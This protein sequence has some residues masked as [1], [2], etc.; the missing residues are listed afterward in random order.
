MNKFISTNYPILIGFIISKLIHVITYLICVKLWD[1]IYVPASCEFGY[2][3][4]SGFLVCIGWIIPMVVFIEKCM[5][6]KRIT[7]VHMFSRALMICSIMG[8]HICLFLSYL[9]YTGRDHFDY[10]DANHL[11]GHVILVFIYGFMAFLFYM[12]ECYYFAIYIIEWYKHRE[13]DYDK[14]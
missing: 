12:V 5:M 13:D 9:F 14:Y 8:E 11:Y 10:C 2:I 4:L 7:V 1:L 6:L 3:V